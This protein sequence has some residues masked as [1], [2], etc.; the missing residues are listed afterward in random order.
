[1]PWENNSGGPWGGSGGGGN[2]GNGGGGG[3]NSPWGRPGGGGGRGPGG[4]PPD[5]EEMV[6]RGQEKL[7]SMMPGGL[8]GKGIVALVLLVVL[9]WLAT[10]FYRVEPQQ[11][12]AELVFGKLVATTE[13]GLNYNFPAPI[14]EVLLP[15]VTAINQVNIGFQNLSNGNKRVIDEESLMLTGDE[16]IV[17]V[18]FSVFWKISD[19]ESYLFNVR[20]PQESVRNAAEA[21]MREIVGKSG[22]EYIRTRGR[23]AVGLDAQKRIQEILD[24]YNAGIEITQVNPQSV[25]PPGEVIGAFRDVQAANADRER[26]INQATA[27]FNEVTQTAEGDAQRILRAAEAYKEERVNQAQGDSQ[28]FLSILTEF[29]QA[30]DITKRRIYLQTME[31][32]LERM[33]KVLIQNDSQG[34]GQGVL[35]YLPLDRLTNPSQSRGTNQ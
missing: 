35:P 23:N 20:N 8:G 3:P 21:A 10:G 30:P 24:S 18:Q 4:Q 33:N 19:A 6:R 15:N 12:G 32:I 29:E 7:K 1:M 5:V 25:E 31:E 9:G 16:N 13:P 27:Y 22:F 14:G 17:A 2:R 11:R 28:R 26:M 34:G